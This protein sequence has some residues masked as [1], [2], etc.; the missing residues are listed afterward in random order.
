MLWRKIGKFQK[1]Q[2]FCFCTSSRLIKTK[3][4]MRVAEKSE[5]EEPTSLWLNTFYSIYSI[6]ST[7]F[8][9]DAMTIR[10]LVCLCAEILHHNSETI[11]IST[12]AT[13]NDQNKTAIM[14]VICHFFK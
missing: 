8:C 2:V 4:Q 12:F 9:C 6:E 5:F 10:I 7:S 11:T 14:K 1:G 13:V 3:I